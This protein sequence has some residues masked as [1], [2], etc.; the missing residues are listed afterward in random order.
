[1]LRCRLC[2]FL[3]GIRALII[4][5][6]LLFL[7]LISFCVSVSD[8]STTSCRLGKVGFLRTVNGRLHERPHNVGYLVVDVGDSAVKGIVGNSI[9]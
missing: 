3:N 4:L 1:M 9:V 6:R 7:L 5:F 8:G 2:A